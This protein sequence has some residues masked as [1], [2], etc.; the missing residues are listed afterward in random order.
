M[1]KIAFLVLHGIGNT[2][3]GFADKMIRGLRDQLG[4]A[5]TSAIEFEPCFW[6]DVLDRRE[7][8]LADRMAP[9]VDK[10]R[11][12]RELVLGGFGD[13]IAYLGMPTEPSRYYR[14]IHGRI[15]DS[16]SKLES[17]L[18]NAGEEPE[19]TPLVIMGH[20][21]GCFL[22]SNYLWDHQQGN[23]HAF[24]RSPFT[25][26]DT[27][28][29]LITFGCNLPLTSLA[30][31]ESDCHPVRPFGPKGK[32]CFS[33]HGQ[34]LYSGSVKWHNFFDPDD[35]LGFPLAP[36]NDAYAAQVRDISINTGGLL[37]AHTAY[38]TDGDFLD[39]VAS[40]VRQLLTYLVA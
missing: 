38:W 22:A 27:L 15:E 18:R 20:S 29:N 21:L 36:V 1:A 28:V 25:R 8:A 6:G 4:P 24:A 40:R 10:T 2:G 32:A 11:I 14:P 39:E 37:R 13:L 31:P 3:P 5:V 26:C 12:R 33:D 23:A 19:S 30:F 34:D 16:L 17:K 7:I 9:L 35:I